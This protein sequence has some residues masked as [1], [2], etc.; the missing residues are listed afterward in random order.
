ML[1]PIMIG[2]R[3]YYITSDTRNYMLAQKQI[4]FNKKE[5]KEEI[6]YPPEWYYGTLAGLFDG[7]FELKLKASD[8]KEISELYNNMVS[9][10]KELLG[11]ADKYRE[12][13]AAEFE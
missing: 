7:L 8:A 13:L 2:T 11:C 4:S 5:D 10:K 12:E 9:I 6:T 1:I 3:Q